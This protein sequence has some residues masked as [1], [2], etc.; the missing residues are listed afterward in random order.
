MTEANSFSS[1]SRRIQ[2][3]RSFRPPKV[4]S[5]GS[6]IACI[7]CQSEKM[8]A[9]PQG[10]MSGG[11]IIR[12]GLFHE[13]YR[14]QE[15]LHPLRMTSGSADFDLGIL[16]IEDAIGVSLIE[17]QL[18]HTPKGVAIA[19]AAARK[20]SRKM[21]NDRTQN[22]PCAASSSDALELLG[23][24]RW[25]VILLSPGG[26]VNAMT[27]TAGHL[28]GPDLLVRAGRLWATDRNSNDLLQDLVRACLAEDPPGLLPPVLVRQNEKR[29][30]V[31]QALSALTG[32]DARPDLPDH[33]LK[34]LFGLTRSEARVAAQIAE[35]HSVECAAEELQI[36]LGT[37]RNHLKSIFSK[38][39]TNRQ[40]EL[41]ALLWRASHLAITP[42]VP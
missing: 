32:L 38:T 11:E 10:E 12:Q 39:E 5:P 24:L 35:G 1:F 18:E 17:I 40:G 3:T 7:C 16:Q 19:S 8:K 31:I 2:T 4:A 13:N 42:R 14:I 34:L 26:V 9:A 30:L 29:S 37:A 23:L 36:S 15:P 27:D 33:R 28:L 20:R 6:R 21:P 25:P 22:R 41:V